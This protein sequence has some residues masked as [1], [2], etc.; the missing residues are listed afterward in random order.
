M[1]Y[2]L[3]CLAATAV[4]GD[5]GEIQAAVAAVVVAELSYRR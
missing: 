1:T 4:A 2:L 5:M 3:V